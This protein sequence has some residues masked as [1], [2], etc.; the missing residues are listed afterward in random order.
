MARV[1]TNPN[2]CSGM[3]VIE[4]TRILVSVILGQLAGGYSIERVLQSFPELQREDVV[5]A[6]EY[7]SAAVERQA[8]RSG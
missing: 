5:A 8:A 6:I 1:T 7:A 2:V 4:G 3:P